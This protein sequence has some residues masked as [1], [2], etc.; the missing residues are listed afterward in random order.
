MVP[1]RGF[2]ALTCLLPAMLIAACGGGDA[3][4]AARAPMTGPEAP[5]FPPSLD[6]LAA[7][8]RPWSAA[9]GGYIV[10]TGSRAEVLLFYKTV[11]ASS[12]QV[13]VGWSGDTSACNAGDSSAEN[14]AAVLRRINWFR[15]MAGVPAAV[16]LDT[17]F[18][19]KAQQAAMLMAANGAL[20]HT[21]PVGWTCFNATASEAAAKSNLT[22]GRSG[23]ESVGE[24]YMRD[25]GANNTIVG[26]RRWI[27]YPQTQAMG[28]G[29]VGGDNP[30]NALWV[31]DA[32]IHSARPA[33]RDDFVAWPPKGYAP[34]AVVYARWSFS[35][36]GADFSAATVSM[37]ENGASI[38]TRKEVPVNGFGENTLVWYP[39][40]YADGMSWARPAADTAYQV[41][42]SNVVVSGVPRSFTYT[43][44]VFDADTASVEPVTISGS[45]ALASNQVG[46]YGFS[47]VT[48]ASTYQ[49][50][51][52][53]MSPLEF[54]DGAEMGAGHFT[55]S[56]SAG[57]S[58]VATDVSANGSA[59]FHFAH[60]EAADQVM[61]LAQPVVA[62]A[63]A[64][65]HFA[66]RLGLSSP[67]Q[68][69]LV[70]V[71]TD[72]GANW[73]TVFEQA[74][75]QSGM[76]SDFG[77][78]EF[79]SRS[80]SL[81][82]YANRTVLLRW[83]YALQSGSWYPQTSA[84]VGWYVDDIQ[85]TGFSSV[86]AGVATRADAAGFQVAPPGGNFALQARAGMYGYFA[87][88]G[89]LKTVTLSSAVTGADCLFNY[90]QANYAGLFAP[91][92]TSQTAGI[93]Y[94][95]HYAATNTYL[96]VNASDNN[97]YYKIG[98]ANPVNAGSLSAWLA[99]A[100]C[101]A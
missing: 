7:G 99:A 33:V 35:Y 65:L 71:S 61:L 73:T 8:K 56:T 18:N 41:T 88:W 5:S 37:T 20:S 74:G 57:Y 30:V 49:W 87:D 23:A 9:D 4:V 1:A 66:S 54:S 40:A 26:H 76:T 25:S 60:P 86:T 67:V 72:E 19:Q 84:A 95:R 3:P 89:P 11:Y 98:N 21:P 58:L 100:S 97:V 17:T 92:S 48:G 82:A 63:D 83:R 79:T 14:K 12:S 75:Q 51:S 32:N 55:A 22:I 52:L 96:G 78:M 53:T 16:Q 43:T 44:T 31:Q 29:D 45:A 42:I 47:A 62:S 93:Y 69:A 39:G 27:L 85:L 34:H 68:R 15:A 46:T 36:P 77:E 10:D 91:A 28:T 2:R 80:V 94:F 50:R 70:E 59:S 64:T 6:G 90:A 24:S 13:P 38:A 81:A 101:P